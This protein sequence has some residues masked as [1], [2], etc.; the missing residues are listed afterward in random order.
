MGKQ[1]NDERLL[2]ELRRQ[3][4]ILEDIRELLRPTVRRNRTVETPA[5]AANDAGW[6]AGPPIKPRDSIVVIDPA[7]AALTTLE[8]PESVAVNISRCVE[9]Q[10]GRG[11]DGAGHLTCIYWHD[12]TCGAAGSPSQPTDEE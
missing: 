2:A 4:T 11:V 6:T 3:R 12:G 1:H 7:P 9:P 10:C 5:A 8:E